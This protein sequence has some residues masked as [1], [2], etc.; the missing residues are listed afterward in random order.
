M[1]APIPEGDGTGLT[2]AGC[3]ARRARLWDALP[4]RC[5]VLVLADPAHLV[6]FANYVPSPFAF[7]TNESGALLLLEPGRAT[8][9]ADDMMGPFVAK[10][11]VDDTFAP[12]WYD[13]DKTPDPRRTQLVESVLVRLAEG[14]A[15][16]VGVDEATVPAG[17]VEGLR[18]VHPSVEVADL[19]P[20]VGP[21]RRAKDPD[22]L[23]VIARA[24]RAGEAAHARALAEVRP[25]MT[26]LDACLLVQRAAQ[27]SLGEPAIIYGDFASGP[28]TWEDK[29]GPPT[30]R[31]IE[32]GDLLLLD[33]SVIVGGYRGDFTNTFVVGGAP[34][35]RQRELFEACVN[36]LRVAESKLAP[37]VPAREVDA[38][39]RKLFGLLGFE[40]AFPH[41]TGHGI[42]L[43][44][45]EAP[46]FVPH[47]SDT[48]QVGDVVTVEPGLYVDGIGGM[49][50]E[51]NY[52]ITESGF[53]NLTNH[54]IRIQQ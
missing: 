26:E 45:P 47:S 14:G 4:D 25:G 13:G 24:I 36:A 37:G 38:A 52:V 28:R 49:R 3:A 46:F 29:G 10:A 8:L 43:G 11:H 7:R 34:T 9:V 17:V 53:R 22:E 33:F 35:A 51:R 16:R 15:R 54:E 21:M 48:L 44:H 18:Q 27:E 20:I 30:S 40:K 12:T 31:V 19:G 32:E 5:D 39:V 2:A 50:F 42:G 41:H 6:Y 1:S 23:A